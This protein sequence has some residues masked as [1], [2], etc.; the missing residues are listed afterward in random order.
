LNILF[1]L[2]HPGHYH[3]FKNIIKELKSRGNSVY[4]TIQSKDVL[5]QLLIENNEIYHNVLKSGRKS[6]RLG[7]V[8]GL[9][10]RSLEHL[11]LIKSY[12]IKMLVSS[13]AELGPLAKLFRIPY[14]AVFEDDLTLFP[15]FGRIFGPFIS[16]LLVPVSCNTGE[17]SFKTIKY[18]GNQE[19]AYLHPSNF[20]PDL[21]RI[22]KYINTSKK[23]F[24][25]RFSKLGAWHDEG[26]TGL[27]GTLFNKI[28]ELLEP[29]GNILITSEIEVAP[30]HNKYLLKV[31]VSDIHHVLSFCN[32]YIGDSQTMTAEAAVLGTPAIRFNDFVGKIGYLEEL[33]HKY[34]L[35]YGVETNSPEKLLSQIREWI[36][37]SDLEKEFSNRR[38]KM[39]EN[40]ID[41]TAFM[42]WFIENYPKSVKIM[43]EN[44]DYQNRFR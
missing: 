26:K 34:R 11:K 13:S 24:L 40:V 7:I 36:N 31:P 9:F 17:W 38:K 30:E 35:T 5:E 2:A 1:Y 39:L 15:F 8:K 4:I 20:T 23:N 25:I 19:L 33:M 12:N 29:H 3:L 37:I 27:T 42:V 43:K 18:N 41:V 14:I 32:L 21:S 16:T 28:I 44:P 22:T 6:T 10:L